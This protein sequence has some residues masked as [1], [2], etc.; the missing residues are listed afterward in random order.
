MR[1]PKTVCKGIKLGGRMVMAGGI[2]CIL[3]AVSGP[4]SEEEEVGKV[5]DIG[6]TVY[7]VEGEAEI[8]CSLQ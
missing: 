3:S 8:L 2:Q 4:I 6:E 1:D 5:G 7:L